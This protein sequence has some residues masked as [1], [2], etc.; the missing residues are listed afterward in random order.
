MHTIS[1]MLYHIDCVHVAVTGM[2]R[3]PFAAT[4]GD[5]WTRFENYRRGMQSY[6]ALAAATGRLSQGSWARGP[7]RGAW[8]YLVALAHELAGQGLDFTE[9]DELDAIPL[10]RL[11]DEITY[12]ADY[13]DAE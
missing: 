8:V 6:T 3:S 7:I 5:D 1:G 2:G 12:L 4:T 13:Q 10:E 9:I 11:D